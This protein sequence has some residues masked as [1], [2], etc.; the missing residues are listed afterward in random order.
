MDEQRNRDN[1]AI[2]RAQ[3]AR[4]DQRN[5][6]ASAAA[7]A[8]EETRARYNRMADD[9]LEGEIADM[10]GGS[11]KDLRGQLDAGFEREQKVVDEIN[12]LVNKGKGRKA[13][14]LAKKNKAAIKKAKKASKG[15][16]GKNS[17]CAVIALILLGSAYLSIHLGV[18]GVTMLVAALAH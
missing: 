15:K 13:K 5:A 6:D 1:E 17:N 2:R 10:L 4:K 16:K 7:A 11:L 3:Q 12:K 9:E 14:S 18:W 8:E